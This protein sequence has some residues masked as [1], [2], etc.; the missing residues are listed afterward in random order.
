MYKYELQ[1]VSEIDCKIC[2]I[3]FEDVDQYNAHCSNEH[4]QHINVHE[5]PQ[6]SET[7]PEK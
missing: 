5:K 6:D 4:L 1:M 2:D 7:E 3:S